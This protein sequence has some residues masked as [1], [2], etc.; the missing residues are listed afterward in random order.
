VS[1]TIWIIIG[2]LILVGIAGLGL[3]AHHVLPVAVFRAS[4]AWMPPPASP[5]LDA[6]EADDYPVIVSS[7]PWTSPE[8]MIPGSAWW[9][10]SMLGKITNIPTALLGPKGEVVLK[11]DILDIVGGE[12]RQVQVVSPVPDASGGIKVKEVFSVDP[13]LIGCAVRPNSYVFELTEEEMRGLYAKVKDPDQATDKFAKLV[14][15]DIGTAIEK[16]R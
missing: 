14:I 15:E 10:D 13:A 6:F 5:V 7:K 2:C 3:R 8:D 1:V 12:G 11:D 4:A 9:R 16:P